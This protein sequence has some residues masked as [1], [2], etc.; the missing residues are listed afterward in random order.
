MV[1]PPCSVHSRCLLCFASWLDTV[2]SYI[3][4]FDTF[5]LL[6]YRARWMFGRIRAILVWYDVDATRRYRRQPSR[7]V[8]ATQEGPAVHIWL[9]RLMFGSQPAARP[10]FPLQTAAVG[11]QTHAV[12]TQGTTRPLQPAARR[13]QSPDA[14][15]SSCQVV[16]LGCVGRGIPVMSGDPCHANPSGTGAQPRPNPGSPQGKGCSCMT[17]MTW[18]TKSGGTMRSPGPILPLWGAV[19]VSHVGSVGLGSVGQDLASV[20]QK[21]AQEKPRSGKKVE[22]TMP[23]KIWRGGLN[24]FSGLDSWGARQRPPTPWAIVGALAVGLLA[25]LFMLFSIQASLES[26]KE[27]LAMLRREGVCQAAGMDGQQDASDSQQREVG[28]PVARALRTRW[29]RDVPKIPQQESLMRPRKKHSVLHLVPARHSNNEE[30]DAT[31]I[32]WTPFLQQG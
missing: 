9:H 14:A 15:R 6:P 23:L 28:G 18:E 12:C 5:I 19:G 29:T 10:L 16:T 24:P 8:G 25:C 4:Y 30:G 13:R 1:P 7:I 20:G 22:R 31:E 17:R 27:E 2:A 21:A 32:W 3:L 11:T 26:L